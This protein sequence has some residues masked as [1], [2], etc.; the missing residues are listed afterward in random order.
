MS[1]DLLAE[2]LQIDNGELRVREA[3]GLGIELDETKLARY[4]QDH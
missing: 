4:R 3:P 2:P 1:D